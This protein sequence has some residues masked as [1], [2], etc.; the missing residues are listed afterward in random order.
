MQKKISVIIPTY[1]R[2]TELMKSIQTVMDQTY[3]GDIEIII[4]DDSEKSLKQKI[5]KFFSKTLHKNRKIN[6]IHKAKKEGAPLA[7]NIGIKQSSGDYIA[8]LD[9][10]DLWKPKKIE[11]QV[12]LL[13]KN[14]DVAL[15]ICYSLDKRFG[16]ERICKPPEIITHEMVLK[17]F[18]LSSSSSYL[19][20]KTALDELGGFDITLPS[21]QEYDLAIRLSKQ[22]EVRCVPEVLM[23]QHETKGQISENWNRKI[24]GIIAIYKKHTQDYCSIGFVDGIKNHMKFVGMLALFSIGF[25][26]G[27]K[28]YSVMIPM[29]ERYEE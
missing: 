19:V 10:D 18:N 23:I 4:V 22:Y 8:F 15:V 26:I 20:R 17:S 3:K 16:Q 7:R 29:K 11:K 28:I 14:K 12:D 5:D 9:D 24:K 21:A 6:Y 13:E 1:N 27:N 25:V 2:E